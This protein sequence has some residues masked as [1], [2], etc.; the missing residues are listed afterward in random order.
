MTALDQAQDL[1][2]GCVPFHFLDRR[3]FLN[4]LQRLLDVSIHVVVQRSVVY[5]S[6]ASRSFTEFN[7][8]LLTAQELIREVCELGLI[9][10]KESTASN[11]S[12]GSNLAFLADHP[13]DQFVSFLRML[14]F[15]RQHK[16]GTSPVTRTFRVTERFAT[17]RWCPGP[18]ALGS[19][20]IQS[21]PRTT[22]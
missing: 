16:E 6:H 20:H 8:G 19:A 15:L 11:L 2:K 10:C 3:F 18:P 9:V 4:V 14:A 21:G 17:D 7:S 12:S 5:R 22:A 13:F 1:I